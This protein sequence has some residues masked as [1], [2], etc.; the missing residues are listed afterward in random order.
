MPT[1]LLTCAAT[2]LALLAPAAAAYA[3]DNLTIT[4]QED[5]G[6]TETAGKVFL[7][8]RDCKENLNRAIDFQLVF[9]N[10]ALGSN[11]QYALYQDFT[12]TACTI[13]DAD[14]FPD[15]TD[16]C[17]R[18]QEARNNTA[19]EAYN[20]YTL[21][22][23][24]NI[25]QRADCETVP[26]N[27]PRLFVAYQT[28]DATDGTLTYAAE[29]FTFDLDV[30]RPTSAASD[31]TVTAGQSSIRVNFT[32]TDADDLTFNVYYST[33]PI[34]PG[35]KPE[36]LG[37]AY[38]VRE[39]VT[40][41]VT[42]NDGIQVNATYYVALVT[43]NANG[44]ETLFTE[45]LIATVVT[46]PTDDFYELYRGAGGQDTGFQ[47]AAAPG[48]S[49]RGLAPLAFALGLTALAA[50]GLR[51][52]AALLPALAAAALALP[53]ATAHAQSLDKG[54][55]VTT[56]FFSVRLGSYTPQV[57]DGLGLSSG[58]PYQ[59][60]FG[61]ESML[62]FELSLEQTIYQGI[63]LLNVDIH[64]GIMD[65][66]GKSI[67]A[68]GTTSSDSTEFNIAPLRA[69][70]LYRFDLLARDLNIPLVPVFGAGLDYFIWWVNSGEGDLAT[71][72]GDTG[73]GGV[74]GWHATVGLQLH[75]DWFDRSSANSLLLDFGVIN[76]YF[77]M[78]Y[79]V[80][81]ANGFGDS[82]SI[83]LSDDGAW[84]FGLAFEY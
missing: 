23:W 38:S 24:L 33:S 36:D 72:Q 67:N 56:G 37:A 46:Q 27:N 20:A 32:A 45:D 58:G 13:N 21:A 29:G 1:R 49:P 57:D 82:A 14:A 75:L 60:A 17:D 69:G 70:L 40:D 52:R 2:L 16:D 42:L 26:A 76:S 62:L 25:S 84:L 78:D 83:D 19:S 39:G 63:G 71:A 50:V 53:A 74:L 10:R 4:Y 77:S 7:N 59:R 34:E 66:E 31:L 79:T 64:L 80:T 43:A 61:D 18:V 3:Q 12:G 81:S 28:T 73:L 35:Q 22:Q 47:C 11:E 8:L 6:D 5:F 48:H 44:N 9:A 68:D 15:D 30:V 51:R 54:E 41:G 55:D 65:V